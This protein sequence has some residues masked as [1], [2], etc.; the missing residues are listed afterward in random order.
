M[1]KCVWKYVISIIVSLNYF[2]CAY[3]IDISCYV[4]AL[5]NLM[6]R[7]L[8]IWMS[9]ARDTIFSQLI[10]VASCESWLDKHHLH[11]IISTPSISSNFYL[12]DYK[13]CSNKKSNKYQLSLSKNEREFDN[14][15]GGNLF[16][17]FIWADHWCYFYHTLITL[18]H[19]SVAKWTKGSHL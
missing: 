3:G 10:E 8:L 1:T 7:K 17:T 4:F 6:P 15:I 5:P 16:F 19:I 9:K 18:D 11:R 14:S 2:S 12:N 13:T